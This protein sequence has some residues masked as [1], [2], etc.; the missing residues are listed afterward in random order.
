MTGPE[1]TSM[2]EQPS[3]PEAALVP[4]LPS[5]AALALTYAPRS[6]RLQTLALFALDSRLAGLLRNS[7]EPMLAQLRFAWWRE[8]LGSDSQRW[9]TGEPLL[10]ALRSWGGSHARLACLV[11]G[12]EAMT[13]AAPLSEAAIAGLAQGRADA[14]AALAHTLGR[15]AE[16]EG[17]RR[18]GMRWALADLAMR[19]R[20]ETERATAA[21]LLADHPALRRPVSRGLRPLLVL[22]GLALRRL[23]GQSEDAA[24]SPRALA[25]ALRRGLLGI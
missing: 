24:R 21:A 12:W 7:R 16:G 25:G 11:D 6:A 5:A 8:M 3:S 13:G 14:F 4:A 1:R 2:N 23:V 19:L 15:D 9:P 17:A 10:A 18:I 20:D 22:E